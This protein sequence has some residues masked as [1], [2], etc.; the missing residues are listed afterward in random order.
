MSPYTSDDATVFG[1]CAP[2]FKEF[3]RQTTLHH[4]RRRHNHTRANVF[5]LIDTLVE[6][7]NARNKMITNRRVVTQYLKARDVFENE[8]IVDGYLSPNFFI[9]GID[10]SLQTKEYLQSI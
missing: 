6:K 5:K 7:C 3:A 10:V 2:G 8:G 9:H 4:T 1:I